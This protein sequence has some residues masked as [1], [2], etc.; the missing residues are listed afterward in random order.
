MRINYIL[1]TY[2]FSN[3]LIE[4]LDQLRKY[5]IVES[6]FVRQAIE[7]KLQRDLPLIREKHHQTKLPF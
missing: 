5:R 3:E 1:R 6:R 4:K 7:E 2:R